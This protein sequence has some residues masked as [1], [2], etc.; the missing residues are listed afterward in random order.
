MD[1]SAIKPGGFVLPQASSVSTDVAAQRRQILQASKSV[2]ESGLLGRN[3]LVFSVDS[4]THKTIIR[5]EDSETHEV[6]MQIPPE[7]VLRLA[8][9][10]RESSSET[11]PDPSDT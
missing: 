7:Y 4:Q 8:Q 11:T 3:Q 9:E 1:V 2:N 6:V 5:I 10:L